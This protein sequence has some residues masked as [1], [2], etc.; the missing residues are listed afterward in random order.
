MF[1]KFRKLLNRTSEKLADKISKKEI[2][3]E[4]IEDILWEMEIG[5]VENNVSLEVAEQ[6]IKV[7]EDEIV[8]KVVEK[9]KIKKVIEDALRNV[10]TETV[11]EGNFDKWIEDVEDKKPIVV[12]FFGFNGTGKTTTIA[13]LAYYLKRKGKSV[14]L[15]AGDTFRAAAIEQLEEHA[16]NLEVRLIKQRYGS[17][18]AAVIYDAINYANSKGIDFVLA[19]TAGRAV[20]DKN[21]MEELKKIIRVAKPDL[22]VL[23][24]E[25]LTGNDIVEQAKMFN[26][27]GVDVIILTKYDVDDKKGAAL[28]VSHALKKPILFLGTGQKYEDLQKFNKDQ[29]IKDLLR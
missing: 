2:R 1:T 18:A 29:Y 23:V 15:A 25:S 3:K 22:K 20:T 13:K 10:I 8:G 19:D 11:I 14:V 5:L 26:E 28:S 9:S 21:L 6:I 24:L 27:V 12:V 4:D 16:K 7:I 17:D